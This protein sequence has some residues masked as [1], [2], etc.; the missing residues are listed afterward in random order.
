MYA[1]VGAKVNL[2]LRALATPERHHDAK[3]LLCNEAETLLPG[4]Q[5]WLPPGDVEQGRRIL[6]RPPVFL[7]STGSVLRLPRVD[8]LDGGVLDNQLTH[9]T[10][11]V[12]WKLPFLEVATSIDSPEVL[13]RL[14]YTGHRIQGKADDFAHETP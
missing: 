8:L 12:L 7:I 13:R 6:P 1:A 5:R 11:K 2:A 3:L 4:L 9:L 10:E 14:F